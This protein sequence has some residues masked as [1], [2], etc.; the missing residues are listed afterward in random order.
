[1]SEDKD[2]KSKNVGSRPNLQATGYKLFIFVISIIIIIKIL[3][4]CIPRKKIYL[5]GKMAGNGEF[6]SASATMIDRENYLLVDGQCGTTQAEIYNWVENKFLKTKNKIPQEY[7]PW[8]HSALKLKNGNILLVTNNHFITKNGNKNFVII[9][10]N[11]N[12]TFIP[13]ENTDLSKLFI[14]VNYS[15]LLLV[16]NGNILLFNNNEKNASTM[17]Y[18]F[19]S[20][21]FHLIQSNKIDDFQLFEAKQINENEILL[22]GK[23]GINYIYNLKDNTIKIDEENKQINPKLQSLKESKYILGWE[24]VIYMQNGDIVF[25]DPFLYGKKQR[26]NKLYSKKNKKLITI[27]DF[28]Y[29]RE[30][31]S[32]ILLPNDTILIFG[33]TCG[34]KASK[35]PYNTVE[36]YKNRKD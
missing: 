25:L 2:E 1:M 30:D 12:Q 11:Y 9:Y 24:K 20:K 34:N 33:G 5:N 35:Y 29:P 18:Y 28:K 21:D 8:N 23:K 19:I 22:Y 7:I 13:Y 15:S 17:I 32:T 27:N 26:P 16:N 4:F 3:F 6:K 36:I 14:S 31:Y 10:D